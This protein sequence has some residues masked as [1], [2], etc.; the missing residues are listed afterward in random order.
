MRTIVISATG[1]V[2]RQIVERLHVRGDRHDLGNHDDSLRT[3]SPDAVVDTHAL[4]PRHRHRPGPRSGPYRQSCS[5]GRTSTRPPP[6]CALAATSPR[7][8]SMKAPPFAHSATR[9][10]ASVS[11]GSP[12][13]TRSSTSR[14]AGS[15]TTP[16]V[17][18]LPLVYRPNDGQRREDVVLRRR[19]RAGRTC[20]RVRPLP[21]CCATCSAS[22]PPR[23]RPCSIPAPP[24][25]RAPCSAP[26]RR[27]N[28][29]SSTAELARPLGRAIRAA[30]RFRGATQPPRGGSDARPAGRRSW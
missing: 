5:P 27:W 30:R 23:S 7:S 4:T 26:A 18:R 22:R 6:D 9:T 24:R 28:A 10:A 29:R 19:L 12:S 1:F 3:F 17:L 11:P 14:S 2:D 20:H 25:S 21:C 8:R 16:T 15:P 13:T